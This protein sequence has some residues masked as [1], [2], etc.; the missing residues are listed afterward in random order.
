V[1]TN[2]RPQYYSMEGC[3][4]GDEAEKLLQTGREIASRKKRV[5]EADRKFQPSSQRW[6]T[7]NVA[8]PKPE[9]AKNKGD[10]D[11]PEVC[12]GKEQLFP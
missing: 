8:E 9:R 6:G 3:L 5:E 1:K 12:R 10:L 4:W 2:K 7:G 11:Y